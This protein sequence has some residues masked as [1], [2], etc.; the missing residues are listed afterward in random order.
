MLLESKRGLGVVEGVGTSRVLDVL[1]PIAPKVALRN[2]SRFVGSLGDGGYSDFP[3][4]LT[5][6]G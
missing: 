1:R 4:P 3:P 5:V 6:L 2:W